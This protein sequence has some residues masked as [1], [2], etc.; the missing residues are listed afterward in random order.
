MSRT[1]PMTAKVPYHSLAIL[2]V[3]LAGE[4]FEEDVTQPVTNA[5]Q[6]ILLAHL[7]NYKCSGSSWT[8]NSF[9]VLF[10]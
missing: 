1:W 5:F 9:T 2:Y 7:V 8:C 3:G 4:Q 6:C 10:V